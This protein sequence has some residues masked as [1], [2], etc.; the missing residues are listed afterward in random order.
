M[1]RNLAELYGYMASR[2]LDG[3][4]NQVSAPFEEVERLMSRCS[5][6]GKTRRVDLAAAGSRRHTSR[7]AQASKA[8]C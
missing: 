3:H 4:V 7:S 1:S 2:V 6:A 8:C 5:M